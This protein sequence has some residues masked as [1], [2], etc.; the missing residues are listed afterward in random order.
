MAAERKSAP[1]TRKL[2]VT[3]RYGEPWEV[4]WQSNSG[5]SSSFRR[6]VLFSQLQQNI[7]RG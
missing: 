6:E 4:F 7:C 5:V 1:P 3:Y 2:L